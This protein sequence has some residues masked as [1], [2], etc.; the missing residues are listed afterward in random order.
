MGL[1]TVRLLGTAY[2]QF[3]V[4][5]ESAHKEELWSHSEERQGRSLELHKAGGDAV[6]D[7]WTAIVLQDRCFL[8][9]R[10]EGLRGL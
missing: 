4:H 7:P 6:A 2:K 10:Y 1:R 9:F 8:K 5:R 3:P